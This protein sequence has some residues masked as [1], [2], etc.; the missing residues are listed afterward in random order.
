MNKG[1]HVLLRVLSWVNFD[2]TIGVR[3]SIGSLPSKLTM[4]YREPVSLGSSLS[5]PYWPVFALSSHPNVSLVCRL[6][7]TTKTSL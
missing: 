4:P 2:Y 1:I 6:T 3:Y 5:A 7:T